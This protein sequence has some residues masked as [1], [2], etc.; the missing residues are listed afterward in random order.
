MHARLDEG[1]RQHAHTRPCSCSL[2]LL[3]AQARASDKAQ[4]VAAG[5][6]SKAWWSDFV[7]LRHVSDEEVEEIQVWLEKGV[8]RK[9]PAVEA[10]AWQGTSLREGG[11]ALKK[12]GRRMHRARVDGC[13]AAVIERVRAVMCARQGHAFERHLVTP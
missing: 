4:A 11:V 13:V 1:A 8:R 2:S 7:P 5:A 3:V 6:R 10:G 9:E 12:G